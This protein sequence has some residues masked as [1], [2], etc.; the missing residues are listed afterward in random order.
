MF[1]CYVFCEFLDFHGYTIRERKN[2]S[3]GNSK[4]IYDADE[5][6]YEPKELLRRGYDIAIRK[7]GNK[8][9]NFIANSANDKKHIQVTESMNDQGTCPASQYTG[10]LRKGCHC[11]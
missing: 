7:V 6:S 1:L 2:P 3:G 4:R 11:W 8:E 5:E 10:Q 9:V